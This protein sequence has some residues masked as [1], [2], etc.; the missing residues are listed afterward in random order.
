MMQPE[1]EVILHYV[2]G[3]FA[4]ILVE[5]VES[6]LSKKFSL[7]AVEIKLAQGFG[8]QVVLVTHC[9]AD[10]KRWQIILGWTQSMA[11]GQK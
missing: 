11:A 3:N 9:N 2:I 6:R 1:T 7:E 8:A 5:L 4:K 10:G